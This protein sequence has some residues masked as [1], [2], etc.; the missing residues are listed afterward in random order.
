LILASLLLIIYFYFFFQVLNQSIRGNTY[1]VLLFIVIFLPIYSNFQLIIFKLTNSEFIISVIKFSK[2]LIFYSIF[3]IILFGS[4]VSFFKKKWKLSSLDKLFLLFVSLILFF[5]IFPI[6]EANFISRLLYT[7]NLLL[8]A[9]VYFI[10]RQNQI[11]IKKISLVYKILIVIFL[12]SSIVAVLEFIFGI[13]LHSLL[14]Y[15][16]YNL[17]INDILP[18]GNYQL[19]WTFERQGAF[20]RYGAV[21]ADP[22]EFSTSLLLGLSIGLFHFIHNKSKSNKLNFLF[23]IIIFLIGF[24]I[25][26]SRSAILGFIG[27]LFFS[28]LLLK[29]YKTLIKIFF[30]IIFFF[31]LFYYFSDLD[32]KFFL[33]DTLTFQNTSSLGHLFEWFEGIVSIIENPLGIGLATSGNASS[34]DQAIG[35]GGENQF[36]IIGVQLGLLG[37]I[38]YLSILIK[39]IKNSFNLY[40]LSK[41]NT[42][43]LVSFTITCSKF[44]L[45]VPLMTANAEIYSFISL[46]TWFFVGFCETQY[47]NLISNEYN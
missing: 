20:P 2:D 42:I 35:I 36:I 8:I 27:I 10:G 18:T 12:I 37:I 13:H 25:S 40:R 47:Q 39:S 17:L 4:S 24:Y 28:L 43:K 23:L 29:N 32:T 22:L 46:F 3:T 26:F 15:A 44:G 19:S 21:F 41:N 14:D 1:F 30:S 34:V 16:N 9:I 38:F 45:I 11:D 31:F 7:K 5:L 33:L 6:G